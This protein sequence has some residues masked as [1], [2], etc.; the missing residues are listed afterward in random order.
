MQ[1]QQLQQDKKRL[2][3]KSVGRQPP[4]KKE[5]RATPVKNERGASP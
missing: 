2:R 3:S 4:A 1:D 5:T